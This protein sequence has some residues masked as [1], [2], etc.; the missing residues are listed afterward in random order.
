MKKNLPVSGVETPF[1]AGI[2][3]TRTDLKG[4]VSYANDA[5]VAISGFSREEL[6]GQN[7]NIVRHPDMPP[8]LFDDLWR[9]VKSGHCWR[10]LV[11]N[12]CKNGNHYWVDAFVVPVK[13]KGQI[14]GY[15]SVR[16][17]ASRDAI[18]AAEALYPQLMQGAP[19]RKPAQRGRLLAHFQTLYAAGMTVLAGTSAALL[20][21]TA[22]VA[23][24]ATALAASSGWLWL[25]QRRRREQRRLLTACANIAEGKLTNALAIDA[26]GELGELETALAYMQVHLKVMLDDVQLTAREL[27]GDTDRMQHAIA[28]IY[29]RMAAGNN[30]VLQMSASIEQLSASIEQVSQNAAE[31]AELSLR[32][33]QQ[34]QLGA[35]EMETAYQRGTAAAGAVESTQG[36]ITELTTAINGITVVTQTIHDIAE[37]TNLLALNA[38]IEAARAGESGRG[39]AVVADEVRKLAERTSSSTDEINTLV[40]N[41][42]GAAGSTVDAIASITTQTRAGVEAQQRTSVQ[43]HSVRGDVGDVN[44]MMQEIASANAQQSASATHLAERMTHIATQF[45]ESHQHIDAANQTIRE[46]AQQAG[47]LARLAGHFE[48]S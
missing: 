26:A 25:E 4:A 14:S 15:M 9:T 8:V 3:V 42:R 38:A 48:V 39:F 10:G 18:H 36:V 12:R 1:E 19:L 31:T 33:Q 7:H 32:S 37:Q 46:L 13:E 47:N 27:A 35:A 40:A 30:S 5:F 11:K 21:N 43:L 44:G 34:L 23:I 6:L 24:A 28:D 22:G 2:I 17:P 45:E 41:V 16:S 20:G 29:Q